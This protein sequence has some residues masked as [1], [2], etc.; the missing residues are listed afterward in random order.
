MAKRT[1]TDTITIRLDRVVKE[2]IVKTAG[3]KLMSTNHFVGEV[4]RDYFRRI[5]REAKLSGERK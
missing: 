3:E 4:L 1:D 5:D 2:R